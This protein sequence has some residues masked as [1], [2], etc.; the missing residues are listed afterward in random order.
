MEVCRGDPRGRRYQVDQVW[1]TV[2]ETRVVQLSL[3]RVDPA[4]HTRHLQGLFAPSTQNSSLRSLLKVDSVVHRRCYCG[5]S[6]EL[7]I[8]GRQALGS[9][10]SSSELAIPGRQALGSQDSSSEFLGV[11]GAARTALRS[12][13]E[14]FGVLGRPWLG[15]ARK[16]TKFFS[17]FQSSSSSE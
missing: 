1:G 6:E 16:P 8:P 5:G 10:D 11:L 7:A 12:G 2:Q 13:S 9:Q 3:G 15:V 17:S 4:P 14:Q